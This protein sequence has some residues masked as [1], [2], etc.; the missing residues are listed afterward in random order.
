ME[1]AL[2]SVLSGVEQVLGYGDNNQFDECGADE[3]LMRARFKSLSRCIYWS[4]NDSK[5]QF[6]KLLVSN[7]SPSTRIGVSLVGI[8]SDGKEECFGIGAVR[9]FDEIGNL[10]QG[11]TVVHVSK[12]GGSHTGKVADWVMLVPT[13][14]NPERVII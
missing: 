3:G 9:L 2:I 1:S 14:V 7:L 11:Q 10:W 5:I 8:S 13:S 12:W 4:A 6:R